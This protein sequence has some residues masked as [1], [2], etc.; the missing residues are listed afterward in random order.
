M[1]QPTMGAGGMTEGNDL[2]A[3]GGGTPPSHSPRNTRASGA[4]IARRETGILAAAVTAVPLLVAAG[5]SV[6]PQ[7]PGV[8]FTAIGIAVL[9]VIITVVAVQLIR[10]ARALLIGEYADTEFVAYN[11][12]RETGILL[13]GDIPNVS[14]R[15][16]TVHSIV[17]ALTSAVE[18]ALRQDALYDCGRAVG[19]SWAS[20]FRRELP[21]LE[22]NRK[23]ILQQLLKWSEYDATAG[24]GRL[25]VAINP[26][27]SEGVITL[28]NGFLS[29]ESAGFPLNWWFA[30]YLAG[31]LY[32]LLEQPAIVELAGPT[33]Q[34]T[35][36]TIFSVRPE[37]SK[38]KQPPKRQHVVPRA[39]MQVWWR[40]LRTPLP[41]EVS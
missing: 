17:N 26:A 14:L 25:T 33:N 8:W 29:R 18:P 1:L 38:P 7:L 6:I 20:E 15:V 13:K 32:E 36:T 22:I 30:G 12:N 11:D 40:R 21:R 39:V 3:N 16:S 28:A 4:S 34:S 2:S 37:G 5:I 35:P 27:T 41:D 19:R 24:M 31:T 23:D 9:A 10:S